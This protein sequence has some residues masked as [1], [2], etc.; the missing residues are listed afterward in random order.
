MFENYPDI[1]SIPQI[2][3]M[4]HIGKSSAYELVRSKAINRVKVGRKYIIPKQSVIGF[5]NRSCYNGGQII[6]GGLHLV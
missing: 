4:L 1:V 3:E 5:V 6:D 2:C